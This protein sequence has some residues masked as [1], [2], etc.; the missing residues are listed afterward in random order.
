MVTLFSSYTAGLVV[1]SWLGF[2]P[3]PF[4]APIDLLVLIGFMA[5]FAG[6]STTAFWLLVPSPAR[7]G[8]MEEGVIVEI[9]TRPFGVHQGY[10]WS[11]LRLQGRALVLPRKGPR[12]LRSLRLTMV[13][14]ERLAPR[15]ASR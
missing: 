7:L 13:Q 9:G 5:L 10:R 6:L 4:L 2:W 3:T 12:L 14:W 15:F 11:E 8:I 1:T